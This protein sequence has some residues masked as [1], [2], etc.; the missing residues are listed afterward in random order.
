[1]NH[2]NIVGFRAFAKTNLGQECLAMETC[3]ISLADLIEKRNEDG[4]LAFPEKNIMR[5]GQHISKAL[6]YLHM[7][8]LLL[9]GDIKSHNVLIIKDF[10]VCK[11]CDF[12]VS[13]PLTRNG[14]VDKTKAGEDVE[15]VGT[16]CWCAPEM[17]E[18]PFNNITTKVDIFSF[19]LV[20][21]EMF[22]LDIPH[23]SAINDN[24]D[25][26]SSLEESFNENTQVFGTRPAIP[27]HMFGDNFEEYKYP[28]ELFYC[29][30]EKNPD[31]RP[32]AQHLALCI[33]EMINNDKL[34]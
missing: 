25:E 21:W 16:S 34:N 17:I 28:L 14:D 24:L 18:D 7:R 6:D 33:Y 9:H 8:M 29:C 2:P 23:S 32:T 19:G 26:T 15:Y 11:L 1:M 10:E 5:M 4:L 13:L 3:T 31:D 20:I 22:A 27:Y 30:T 12:G